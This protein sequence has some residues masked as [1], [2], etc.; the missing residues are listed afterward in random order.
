MRASAEG[1]GHIDG[2]CQKHGLCRS[3]LAMPQKFE[4]IATEEKE[5]PHF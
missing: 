2:R 4:K 3:V 5:F 1:E